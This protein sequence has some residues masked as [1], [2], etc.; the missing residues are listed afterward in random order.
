MNL[1]D[2]L[3][4]KHVTLGFLVA[5][6]FLTIACNLDWKHYVRYWIGPENIG[7]RKTIILLRIFFGTSLAAILYENA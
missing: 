1:E 2:T 4:L 5:T 6:F 3:L 7:S